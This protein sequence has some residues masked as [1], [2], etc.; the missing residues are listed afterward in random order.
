MTD[1]ITMGSKDDLH[2]ARR[3]TVIDGQP[4][5]QSTGINSKNSGCWFP[6]VMC[7]G[8]GELD[9]KGLPPKFDQKAAQ[10]TMGIINGNPE[11]YGPGYLIK[12]P[13][14]LGKRDLPCST[15]YGKKL[16]YLLWR[17]GLKEFLM[18]SSRLNPDYYGFD[19]LQK[20]GLNQ[21][22]ITSAKN[23]VEL[24]DT[25]FYTKNPSEVN[26]WLISQG[27]T[28]IKDVLPEEQ[29]LS[30]PQI[31]PKVYL[32]RSPTFFNEPK[33]PIP[34]KSWVQ[35]FFGRKSENVEV[36]TDYSLPSLRPRGQS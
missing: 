13:E 27:A 21:D 22:Q 32:P 31:T 15:K 10:K 25:G 34:E 16:N 23:P 29:S 24:E 4:Y 18:D 5:Y 33:K 3:I 7:R 1:F 28:Y 12:A 19:T 26:M 14:F 30:L 6:F 35:R 8:K 36:G 17:L 2:N 20:V 9:L 11:G